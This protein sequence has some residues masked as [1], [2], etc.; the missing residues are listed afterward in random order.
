MKT[1]KLAIIATIMTFPM[2]V[3]SAAD[4]KTESSPF[5]NNPIISLNE[6]TNLPE[7]VTDISSAVS[8]NTVDIPERADIE[9]KLSQSKLAEGTFL[10]RLTSSSSNHVV[11]IAH[12]GRTPEQRRYYHSTKAKN[13]YSLNF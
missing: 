12:S 4:L 3:S 1:L 6:V 5:E 13:W 10:D 2:T 7:L 11:V 9:E 8:Q